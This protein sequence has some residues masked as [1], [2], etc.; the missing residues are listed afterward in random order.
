MASVAAGRP[1]LGEMWGWLAEVAEP[2]IPVIS[3]VDLGIV[4]DV[5][6]DRG[7]SGGNEL[8]VIVTPT[9]SG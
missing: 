2:E 4:R 9:N 1:S 5:R 7:T 3:V 6:W 8:V